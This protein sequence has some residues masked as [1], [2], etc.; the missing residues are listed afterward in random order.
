V[1]RRS[2]LP[3]SPGAAGPLL[4]PE[5][6]EDLSWQ[7]EALCAEIDPELW[8]PE[9]GGSTREAKRICRS[10]E[11]RAE[12]LEYALENNEMFGIFGGLSYLERRPLL[13]DRVQARR[14][15]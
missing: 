9:K 6:A 3:F 2:A 11:V 15:A 12:C 14:A 4:G 1:N 10:C 7:A 5:D 13:R 8:F